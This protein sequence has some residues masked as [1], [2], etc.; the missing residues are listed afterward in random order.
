MAGKGVGWAAWQGNLGKVLA[1]SSA[2]AAGVPQN[3]GSKMVSAG[4]ALVSNVNE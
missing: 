2:M 1:R 4:M 3:L